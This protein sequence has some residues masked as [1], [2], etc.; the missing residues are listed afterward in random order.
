MNRGRRRE[1]IFFQKSDHELFLS[2]LNDVN[3]LFGIEIHAYA[4]LPN[5]YHILIHTPRGNLSRC[6]RHLNGV[7]TQKFNIKHK[8]D[9]SLFRGRYKSILVEKEEYLLELVRYIHRNPF[10]A[11][12]EEKIGQ[13]KWCSHRGYMKAN[14]RQKWLK[15]EDVLIRFSRYEKEAKEELNAF[16]NEEIPRDLLKRL[17]SINWPAILGGKDFKKK[18]KEEY[19][20]KEID[21]REVPEYKRDV[22]RTGHAAEEIKTLVEEN[23][24]ILCSKRERKYSAQRRAI[25]YILRRHYELSLNEIS[26]IMGKIT[27]SAVSRQYR[28]AEEDV[29]NKEGCCKDVERM[30]KSL[31]FNFKT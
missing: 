5:H 12:L 30:A 7:Y 13:Y 9:G 17:E 2:V 4:L 31:K 16:V 8:I 15:V 14:E 28:L 18:I 10:K 26:E 27:Y 3:R 24:R 19:L 11:G 22:I 25:V 20:G 29:E 21:A 23:K 6:M 1:K